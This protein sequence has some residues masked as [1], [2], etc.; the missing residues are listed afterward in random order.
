[1]NK[2]SN[3]RIHRRIYSHCHEIYKYCLSKAHLA[4]LKVLCIHRVFGFRCYLAYFKGWS[5]LFCSRLPGKPWLYL[6]CNLSRTTITNLAKCY[7]KKAFQ[8]YL[9]RCDISDCFCFQTKMDA[10]KTVVF[11]GWTCENYCTC[12]GQVFKFLDIIMLTFK[13]FGY[14]GVVQDVIVHC[15]VILEMTCR[16]D[17]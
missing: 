11:I 12:T 13:V 2:F 5:G 8:T 17:F 15:F 10:F 14:G 7:K 6:L 16:I 3:F 9:H 4:V 1:M